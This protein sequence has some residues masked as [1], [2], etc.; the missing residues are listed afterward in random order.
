MV[1][2]LT[3]FTPTYNRAHTLRR[4]YE[5]LCTQTV[6]E[7]FEW[8]VIDDGSTDFTRQLIEGFISEKRIPI[9]YIYKENGG[10]H[11][12][13]NTAYANIDS[14]L[15]VCIDSDD[16][17]PDDA[18]ELILKKWDSE[19]SSKYAGLVGLDYYLDSDTP[20][21]GKLPDDMASCWLNELETRGIHRGDM[22]QVMRTELMK[23]VA[24]QIGYPGEKNF[25]PVYMLLQV[26]DRLPLLVINRNLCY[27]D[28]QTGIDSMSERIFLQYLDSPRSF[29]KL[30]RLEM[31]LRHTSAVRRFRVAIHYVSSCIIARDRRW[32]ADS[33]KKLL[34][35]LAAPAGYLL[36]RYIRHKAKQF[37]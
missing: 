25:N 14:E 36:S 32:L 15:C 9:R 29:A 12:G 34:T 11:T 5:S 19:G 22:K 6:R 35:L 7:G 21:G 10:L 4:V 37:T 28:Y 1:T 2:R 33:P 8:L 30:R 27:V 18:V 3:V 26:C 20:I 16:F 17:M 24:P 23:E 31:T 13:Y